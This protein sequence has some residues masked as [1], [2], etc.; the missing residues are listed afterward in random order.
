MCWLNRIDL[1]LVFSLFAICC[2][3][4]SSLGQ[5]SAKFSAEA[6]MLKKTLVEKHIQPRPMDDNYSAWVFDNT[7][8]DLDP[9]RV[10]FTKED[11]NSLLVY[12][13]KIDEEL[14]GAGWL[15]LTQL[16]QLYQK[17]LQRYSSGIKEVGVQPI[18][19]FSQSFLKEDSSWCNDMRALRTH[20]Q[21][22]FRFQLQKRLANLASRTGVKVEKEFLIKNESAARQQVSRVLSRDAERILYHANGFEAYVASVFFQSMS[23]GFDPHTSYFTTNQMQSFISSLS[24]EGFLFGFTI[25][26]NESG[27][28]IISHLMPGGPAWNS[29]EMHKGDVLQAIRWDGKEQQDLWGVDSEEVNDILGEPDLFKI[30]L[31]LKKADGTVNTVH[32]RKEKVTAEENAVKSF[33]LDGQKKIGFISLP[34]FYSNWGDVD[35]AK[36]ASDVAREIVKLKRENIEGLILDVRFNGGGSMAEAVAMAGIFIDAGPVGVMKNR[37]KEP[38]TLKDIN[39]GTIYDGPLV[40]MVNSLSASASEFLA[41]ALQDYNRALIVGARTYGKATAQQ[42]MPADPTLN[43]EEK[44]SKPRLDDIISAAGFVKVTTEKLYRIT[45]KTAQQTG[46]IP[47]IELPDALQ[48]LPIS[49]NVLP[50]S[51]APDSIQKKVYYEPLALLPRSELLEKSKHRIGEQPQFKSLRNLGIRFMDYKFNS[52]SVALKWPDFQKNSE[53]Y[54]KLVK[55]IAGEMKT[56]GKVF[57]AALLKDGQFTMQSDSYANDFNNTWRKNLEEDLFVNETFLITCDLISYVTKK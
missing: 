20:W 48:E 7:I 26:E 46:V 22:L 36:C 8:D 41:A 11:L 50:L 12:R 54:T 5:T 51:F 49:E 29:G 3:T 10:Y 57:K 2:V 55:E 31:T 38:F 1:T 45:G 37:D 35:G 40:I 13:R 47:D 52:D 42:I 18:D 16:T 23:A 17:C 33:V 43:L 4:H 25:E 21:Q 14:N 27:E 44:K 56:S 15:F 19:F 39:R 53:A 24:T 34:D 9:D 32:L 28:V 6:R 30:E